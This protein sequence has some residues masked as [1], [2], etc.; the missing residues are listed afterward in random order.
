[1]VYIVNA[2]CLYSAYLV[3][4]ITHRALGNSFAICQ[5][6]HKHSYIVSM[7]SIFSTRYHSY[8]TSTAIWGSV[9]ILPKD[10]SAFVMRETEIKGPRAPPPCPQLSQEVYWGLSALSLIWWRPLC[11]LFKKGRKRFSKFLKTQNQ[12]SYHHLRF[13][14]INLKDNP[15]KFKL[16]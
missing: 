16:T 7:C 14:V 9:S 5:F 2:L 8:N 12:W 15:R 1:M 10:P 6:T 13:I 3:L 4:M 11:Q